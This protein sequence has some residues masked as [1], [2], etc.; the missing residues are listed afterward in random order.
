MM[1]SSDDVIERLHEAGR[2]DLDDHM[3]FEVQPDADR[4]RPSRHRDHR[5][6]KQPFL[7]RFERRRN[8]QDDVDFR[9]ARSS[10]P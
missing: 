8:L 1:G 2:L 3:R 9:Q 5:P 10:S 6:E 4:R 7:A